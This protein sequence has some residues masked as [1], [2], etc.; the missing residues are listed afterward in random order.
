MSN[1]SSFIQDSP[2][3]IVFKT[4]NEPKSFDFAYLNEYIGLNPF[5]FIDT[6]EIKSFIHLN[7]EEKK[8]W[9]IRII[10]QSYSKKEQLSFIEKYIEF[11]QEALGHSLR[12]PRITPELFLLWKL[13]AHYNGLYEHNQYLDM[14]MLKLIYP[15]LEYQ[16]VPGDGDC[17]FHSIAS[18]INK[19]ASDV[20]VMTS[21]FIEGSKDKPQIVDNLMSGCP[22]GTLKKHFQKDKEDFRNNFCNILKRSCLSKRTDGEDCFWGGDDYDGLISKINQ[23]PVYSFSFKYEPVENILIHQDE[24]GV[25]EDNPNMRNLYQ[26]LFQ[27]MGRGTKIM[28]PKMSMTLSVRIS[29]E[30]KQTNSGMIGHI[31]RCDHFNAVKCK[32]VKTPAKKTLRSSQ[33]RSPRRKIQ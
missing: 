24:L 5:S 2:S 27:R 21:E 10:N 23:L 30:S 12:N 22:D 29:D 14:D 4:T 3:K 33:I 19:T 11:N 1:I 16:E 26:M 28:V 7:Y 31:Y 9:T 18:N 13:I 32:I 15:N 8:A 20:R 25:F 6:L 17:Y